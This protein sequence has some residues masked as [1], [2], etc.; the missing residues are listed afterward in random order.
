MIY[1][2]FHLTS[3]SYDDCLILFL[4]ILHVYTEE[5]KHYIIPDLCEYLAGIKARN[6][7]TKSIMAVL[8]NNTVHFL[9]LL[10]NLE[11]YYY[12][13]NNLLICE[14]TLF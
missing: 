4:V 11:L 14:L 1:Q 6:L 13:Y 9:S 10:R 5:S 12:F 2:L 3:I 8:N 7:K